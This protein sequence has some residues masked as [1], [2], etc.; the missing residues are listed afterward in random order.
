MMII[1]EPFAAPE[2]IEYLVCTQ[3]PVLLNSM[4]EKILKRHSIKALGD[5][6]FAARVNAGGRLI[7]TSENAF[8]W[9]AQHIEDEAVTEASPRSK[10][11]R[12]CASCWRQCTQGL[13]TAKYPRLS[14]RKYAL[15]I[16][17]RRS[18]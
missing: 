13:S 2:L 16:S 9:I 14:S 8:S 11:K 15:K 18:C 4:A 17:A 7:C 3:E 6:E 1:D 10:I 5:E 12:A